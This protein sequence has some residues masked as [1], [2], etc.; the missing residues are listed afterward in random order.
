MI[1]PPQSA[2]YRAASG[3]VTH[4]VDVM[5]KGLETD[6]ERSSAAE[7]VMATSSNDKLANCGMQ[8]SRLRFVSLFSSTPFS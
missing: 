7:G 3:M 6:D 5:L 8:Y 2:K 4:S 1:C